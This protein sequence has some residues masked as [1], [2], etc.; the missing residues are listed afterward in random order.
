MP[1]ILAHHPRKKEGRTLLRLEKLRRK[2]P[3]VLLLPFSSCFSFSPCSNWGGGF[4]RSPPFS[5]RCLFRPFSSCLSFFLLHKLGRRFFSLPPFSK[6]CLF[7]ALFLV[8]L[9]FLFQKMGRRFF[10]LPPFFPKDVSSSC[11]SSRFSFSPPQK[12]GRRFFCSSFFRNGSGYFIIYPREKSRP[13]IFSSRS[14]MSISSE[15]EAEWLHFKSAF[16]KK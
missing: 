1:L 16:R 8:L 7:P 9:I 14:V 11:F 3:D 10:S 2:K 13:K 15:R 4:F 5:K 6:R 12:M